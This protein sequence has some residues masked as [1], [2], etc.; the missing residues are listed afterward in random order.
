H[1]P[2]L[3]FYVTGLGG[4]G[5]GDAAALRTSIERLKSASVVE[6]NAGRSYVRVRFDSHVVSYHQ[7]AQAISDAGATLGRHYDPRLVYCVADYA[8]GDNAAKVDDVFGG[9]RLNSRVHVVALDRDKGLFLVRFLPLQ[10][11]ASTEDPQG[12]NGGH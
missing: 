2:T 4:D 6:V 11:D 8:K 7:V 1:T 3:I 5:M 12:F 10:V 9:K